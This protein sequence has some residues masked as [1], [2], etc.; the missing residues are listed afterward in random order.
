M[1]KGES[2]TGFFFLTLP[3]FKNLFERGHLKRSQIIL[4][5]FLNNKR[6]LMVDIH[7]SYLMNLLA[8]RLEKALNGGDDFTLNYKEDIEKY[9]DK[10]RR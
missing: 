5:N 8:I 10:Q 3:A 7:C 6:I 1:G 9:Y 2:F 4:M